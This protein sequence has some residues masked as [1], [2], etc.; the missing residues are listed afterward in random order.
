MHFL[1]TFVREVYLS[2]STHSTLSLAVILRGQPTFYN[3]RFARCGFWQCRG[4]WA[5]F[6]PKKWVLPIFQPDN[7]FSLEHRP[8]LDSK[9]AAILE[10]AIIGRSRPFSTGLRTV[11]CLSYETNQ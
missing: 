9:T 7:Q 5:Q 4:F 6:W 8:S 3:Q 11:M 2:S 1:G 10:F